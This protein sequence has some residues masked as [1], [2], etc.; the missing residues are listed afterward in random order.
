[1]YLLPRLVGLA[2]AKAL[3]FSTHELSASEAQAMGLAHEVCDP[4]DLLARARH[5]ARALAGASATAVSMAKRGLNMSVGADLRSMLEYEA[6]AQGIAM[7]SAGHGQAV[8]R[9]LNKQAPLYA[10]W[11]RAS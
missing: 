9:F 1:M 8:S 2:R 3:V 7:S 6:T 10:G 11:S 4:K 5:I